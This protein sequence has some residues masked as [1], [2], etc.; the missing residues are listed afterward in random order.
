MGIFR[1][2]RLFVRHG[3][4]LISFILAF[5]SGH[6]AA[7]RDPL[8]RVLPV[9]NTAGL[10]VGRGVDVV[11]GAPRDDCVVRTFD[12]EK[13]PV[14]QDQISSRTREI[15]TMTALN[16]SIGASA[17]AQMSTGLGGGSASAS[18][19]RDIGF[20]TYSLYYAVEASLL[21]ESRRLR[22]VTLKPEVIALLKSEKADKLNVFRQKCGDGYIGEFVMGG[23][24]HAVAIIETGSATEKQN[25]SDSISASINGASGAAS[26][27]SAL[28]K[29]VKTGNVKVVTFQRGGSGQPIPISVDDIQ[30]RIADLPSVALNSPVKLQMTVISYAPLIQEA[31]AEITNLG[32]RESAIEELAELASL[33]NTRLNDVTYIINHPDQFY[34]S[35]GDLPTLA[36]EAKLLKKF[37]SDVQKRAQICFAELGGCKTED[38]VLPPVEIRPARR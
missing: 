7:Q 27:S 20:Q 3:S 37:S 16:K 34:S 6:A 28:Q 24:F 36:T 1:A 33:A 30:K 23:E 2:K 14:G 38:L 21:S 22:D 11:T 9:E 35:P 8:F 10:D 13:L 5:S 26:F 17:S 19:S 29:A 4:V 18:F 12:T 32:E 15:L 31:G 25:I